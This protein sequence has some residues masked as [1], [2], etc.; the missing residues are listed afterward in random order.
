MTF[1]YLAGH[2]LNI[3][4][5]GRVGLATKTVSA[6]NEYA[7]R[8]PGRV[9]ASSFAAPQLT[10]ASAPG[11]TW[12]DSLPPNVR[13]VHSVESPQEV[14]NWGA[15]IVQIQVN[16]PNLERVWELGLPTV[17]TDDNSP[18]VRRAILHS[19][20]RSKLSRVRV[21]LGQRRWQRAIDQ[22]VRRAH[23]FQCNGFAAYD[24]Y[25]RVRRDALRFFDHRVTDADVQQ[26]R[27]VP[28]CSVGSEFTLGF[29]GR[30]VHIKGVE[31]FPELMR[32]LGGVSEGYSL[33]VYGDGPLRERIESPL[34][35]A[36]YFHGFV[37]YD[38]D[39]KVQVREQV[40]LMVL[41]HIQ[42]DSSSTYYESL[43]MGVPVIGFANATLTPLV[44]ET[45]AGWTVPMGDVDALARQIQWVR[46][47]PEELAQARHQ[48]LAF[49]AEHTMSK[50]FDRRLAA[51]GEIIGVETT[52]SAG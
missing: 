38:P 2:G 43:G 39:W 26:S 33:Q 40:D 27:D 31:M 15:Q 42:G 3:D 46:H 14:K 52:T 8:W 45:G 17:L 51:M 22:D 20:A 5:A 29:S 41:P 13:L 34:G 50:E 35:S 16:A 32:R 28:T 19:T 4:E 44:E 30:L 47:H 11:V 25:R 1:L 12:E 10:E 36:A 21:S 18:D 7:H 6:L 49:M 37:V 48:G 24:Y 23:G 9:Y